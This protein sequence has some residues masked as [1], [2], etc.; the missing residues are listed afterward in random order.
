[1]MT[2]MMEVTEKIQRGVMVCERPVKY[3]YFCDNSL[4]TTIFFKSKLLL[5]TFIP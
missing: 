1:M 5:S 3:F 4:T 2:M